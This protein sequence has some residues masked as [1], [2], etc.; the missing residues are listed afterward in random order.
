MLWLPICSTCSRKS[1]FSRRPSS[2]LLRAFSITARHVATRARHTACSTASLRCATVLDLPL[3]TCDFRSPHRKKFVGS[4]PGSKNTTQRPLSWQSY[5]PGSGPGAGFGLCSTL[6]QRATLLEPLGVQ[7]VRR[8]AAASMQATP[9]SPEDR[10]ALIVTVCPSS[11]SAHT[12]S[13]CPGALI[14]HYVVSSS[15]SSS[16]SGVA[17]SLFPPC[18]ALCRSSDTFGCSYARPNGMCLICT[19]WEWLILFEVRIRQVRI[20]RL[21]R[22]VATLTFTPFT[23]ARRYVG[24]TS[25]SD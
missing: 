22:I 1:L 14:A 3:Y 10:V 16:C 5:G 19:E 23:W 17:A 11:P 2:F 8:G 20:F 25:R 4:K 12:D 6:G 9:K 13:K 24:F 21:V 7:P 15:R 18:A